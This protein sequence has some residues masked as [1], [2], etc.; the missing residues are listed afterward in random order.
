[1]TKEALLIFAKNPE[2][3]K[4]KTRLAAT[5][6]NE[7]ALAVYTQLLSHTVAITGN[8]PMDK[9]VFYSSRIECEDVWDDKPYFKQ[10]Q[11]GNDLG[12][13]MNNAFAASF[14][15][16]YDSVV[17]IGTDCPELDE[18][19]IMN[20]FACLHFNDVVI[21]PAEDG[22]YYLLG[23]KQ[24]HSTLFENI[25]WST[26]TVLAETIEI[27]KSHNLTYTLLPTLHDVDE[28]KD[29]SHLNVKV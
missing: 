29:L 26:P 23:M 12:E 6:G 8:L 24:L 10:L 21:G 27:C 5:I 19:T 13:R 28:E 4:V 11:K 9:F 15:K 17:I 14:K 22:G 16:G 18:A 1:M 7:A 20:A 3:G 2:K 25:R